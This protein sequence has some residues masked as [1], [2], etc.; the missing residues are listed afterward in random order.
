[1]KIRITN[2]YGPQ[3][4]DP[5]EKKSQFWLY[6]E[7]EVMKCSQEGYGC[8]ITMDANSWLGKDYNSQDPHNQNNNGKLFHEFLKRNKQLTLLN[9]TEKCQGTI[10]R[11]RMVQGKKEESIIDFIVVCNKVLPH[12]EGMFINEEK[13]ISKVKR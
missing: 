11:S 1:M 4:Y 3:D 5:Q 8:M 7:E 6:L 9:T 10:T 2:G 12:G 13:Q